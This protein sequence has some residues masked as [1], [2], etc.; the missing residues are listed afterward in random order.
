VSGKDVYLRVEKNRQQKKSLF[1]KMRHIITFYM[2]IFFVL[3]QNCKL[4]KKE[5][6]YS[7][8]KKYVFLVK[9]YSSIKS[10]FIY[11]PQ[12]VFVDSLTEKFNETKPSEY[13]NFSEYISFWGF[14]MSNDSFN[15]Y[16]CCKYGD[17]KE[18]LSIYFSDGLTNKNDYTSFERDYSR[19]IK[20]FRRRDAYVFKFKKNQ[21]KYQVLVWSVNVEYCVGDFF[22][23]SFNQKLYS[24]KVVY[25]KEIHDVLKIDNQDVLL[26]SKVLSGFLNN[27][28]E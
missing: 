24:N 11:S 2:F 9:E 1:F 22:M 26:L 23:S 3:F 12:L 16:L 10:D 8:S 7:S 25:L 20:K 14:G 19:N 21:I 18:G 15:S 28:P 4:T 6:A 17:I 13:D 5:Q 27:P